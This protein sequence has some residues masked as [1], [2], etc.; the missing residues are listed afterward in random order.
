MVECF[1]ESGSRQLK[2]GKGG[3]VGVGAAC[4]EG[5]LM[6]HVGG[7]RRQRSEVEWWGNGGGGGGGYLVWKWFGEWE[8]IR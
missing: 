7:E 4:G 5:V 6:G 8:G 3:V 1:K 2:E